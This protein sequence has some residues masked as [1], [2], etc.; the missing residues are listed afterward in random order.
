[1]SF[2]ASTVEMC[3]V[4]SPLSDRQPSPNSRVSRS[5]RATSSGVSGSGSAAEEL[6]GLLRAGALERGALP[7]PSRVEADDVEVADQ[8]LAEAERTRRRRSRRPSRRG[9]PGSPRAARRA[10]HVASPGHAQHGELDHLAVGVGVVEGHLEAGALVARRSCASPGPA[11]R[12]A[13]AP[14]GTAGSAD[15]A[16]GSGGGAVRLSPLP[17]SSS[18]ERPGCPAGQ[19]EADDADHH[20]QRHH[21]HDR[22]RGR[23]R[24]RR[25]RLW[26]RGCG[27]AATL[28]GHPTHPSP[29]RSDPQ[30]DHHRLQRQ[31][32]GDVEL[33]HLLARLEHRLDPRQALLRRGRVG[34]R[35]HV[36]AQ[37]LVDQ[38][39]AARRAGG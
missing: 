36:A 11:R 3:R 34:Q 28:G 39:G 10:C 35:H 18:E 20:G 1:M 8:L 29:V 27:H 6:V 19:A 38:L 5:R 37:L 30:G 7:D 17:P 21:D 24:P 25:W 16:L 12:S 31:Q 32:R 2:A 23:A 26:P 15:V 4:R 9:R 33:Q 14:P 22:R 13:R